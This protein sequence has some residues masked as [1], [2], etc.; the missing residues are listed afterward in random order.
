MDDPALVQYGAALS[1]IGSAPLGIQGCI[2]CHGPAGQ[3][4][5]PNYPYLAGQPAAFLAARLREYKAMPEADGTSLPQVMAGIARRMND[6]EIEALSRYFS[7]IEPSPVK[8]AQQANSGPGAA[9]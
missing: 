9:Q 1:S 7:S 8:A 6:R 3:G 2:N 4:L 5:P